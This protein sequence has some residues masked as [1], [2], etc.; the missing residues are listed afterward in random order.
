MISSCAA[1]S[2]SPQWREKWRWRRPRPRRRK[3]KGHILHFLTGAVCSPSR[4]PSREVGEYRCAKAPVPENSRERGKHEQNGPSPPSP[5]KKAAPRRK[6]SRSSINAVPRRVVR[7]PLLAR[8]GRPEGG[9][10]RGGARKQCHTPHAS[11]HP[12]FAVPSTH[13]D[14]R[15]LRSG[16]ST[17]AYVRDGA[18]SALV[19][20]RRGPVAPVSPRPSSEKK[21]DTTTR[22]RGTVPA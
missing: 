2:D 11:L 8:P 22:P 18:R 4:P 16:R 5:P 13:S 1:P 12:I 15:K 9:C 3:E 14:T 21:S 20:Q 6:V 10:R 7:V 17:A 19:L